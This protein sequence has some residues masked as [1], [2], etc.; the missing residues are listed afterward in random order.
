MLDGGKAVPFADILAGRWDAYI[1]AYFTSLKA[2]P[3]RATVRFA[4]EPNGSRY[5]WSPTRANPSCTSPAQ[6]VQVWRHLS[7]IKQAV[8]AANTS[9][10]F[11]VANADSGGVPFEAFWPG[12]G[13]VQVAAFD[14][15]CGYSGGYISP[16][17]TLASTYARLAA[18]TTSPIWVSELGCRDPSRNDGVPADPSWTKAQWYG[19]L[20]AL[21]EFPRIKHV[22]LLQRSEGAR[23]AGQLLGCRDG[24]AA[25]TP[26]RR[27]R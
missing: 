6:Y 22:K 16:H 15:Y 9:L 4:H 3:H 19:Q 11:C 24:T 18:L 12:S 21:T 8:G 13:Y 20:F 17:D 25:W 2:Y 27:P 23:L 1:K 5:P 26:T 7:A 14:A 10:E